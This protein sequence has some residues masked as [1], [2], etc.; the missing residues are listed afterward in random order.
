MVIGVESVDL[1]LFWFVVFWSFLKL[2]TVGAGRS[3]ISSIVAAIISNFG[4]LRLVTVIV[5]LISVICVISIILVIIIFVIG[6]SKA[7]GKLNLPR[8]EII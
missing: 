7:L 5:I 8:F 4:V 1:I 3:L 2:L 6:G